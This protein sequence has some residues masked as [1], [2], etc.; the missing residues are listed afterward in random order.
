MAS[1]EE[2][3]DRQK[4][5]E[6]TK[7]QSNLIADNG[8]DGKV[9]DVYDILERS[10]NSVI[11]RLRKLREYGITDEMIAEL[12]SNTTSNVETRDSAIDTLAAVYKNLVR[13]INK[14]P[15]GIV[16]DPRTGEKNEAA[17]LRQA[18]RLGIDDNRSFGRL[19]KKGKEILQ[20]EL[21]KSIMKNGPKEN[22]KQN[23]RK[24]LKKFDFNEIL[25]DRSRQPNNE[26]KERRIENYMNEMILEDIKK[27][28]SL[29]DSSVDMKKIPLEERLKY[30]GT[31]IIG[32]MRAKLLPEQKAQAHSLIKQLYPELDGKEDNA[33]IANLLSE[34]LGEEI[35]HNDIDKIIEKV[36]VIKKEQIEKYRIRADDK[37][38]I[39]DKVLAMEARLQLLDKRSP[40]YGI[41]LKELGDFYVSHPEYR[42]FS[43]TL[44]YENGVIT[45]EA[46]AKISQYINDLR[47]DAIGS[48]I[49]KYDQAD[50]SKLTEE[51]KKS[52]ASFFLIAA[53]SESN[54]ELA[55]ESLGLLKEMYPKLRNKEE[56]EILKNVTN[57]VFTDEKVNEKNYTDKID[58]MRETLNTVLIEERCNM[59]AG[60]RVQDSKISDQEVNDIYDNHSVDLH[61]DVDLT[62]TA[63]QNKFNDSK[64]DFNREDEEF[65]NNLY[66]KS[67][68]DSWISSKDEA[69]FHKYMAAL[70]LDDKI[71]VD[72]PNLEAN[73]SKAVG[74]ILKNMRKR[75]PE[76]AKTI[77][78]YTPEELQQVKEK[79]KEFQKSKIN[80]KVIDFYQ[81]NLLSSKT[82]YNDLDDKEQYEFLK[83][84]LLSRGMAERADTPEQK[85]MFLKLS[86]RAFEL[87]NTKDKEFVSFDENGNAIINEEVL[88]DEY[89]EHTVT[90]Y[91]SSKSLAE[92]QKSVYDKYQRVYIFGKMTEYVKLKDSDFV[93]LEAESLD[94]KMDEINEIKYI[95]N[96]ERADEKINQQNSKD[97]VGSE[98]KDSTNWQ[99]KTE[100]ANSKQAESVV[101][102]Q[103]LVVQN[104]SIID[105]I[106][107]GFNDLKG[108]VTSYLNKDN[109]IFSKIKK[110]F[111][112]DGNQNSKINTQRD[113]LEGKTDTVQQNNSQENSWRVEGVTGKIDE[114]KI[115]KSQENGRKVESGERDEIRG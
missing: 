1:K 21:I 26:V 17:S 65:F 109:N 113:R 43:N 82:N 80:A 67:S 97:I 12:Y 74:N 11:T 40:E 28:Q 95:K 100:E 86:N 8:L 83:M 39:S 35:K 46:Q 48:I 7:D 110:T 19:Q 111:T 90:K 30:A 107:R 59:I 41:L 73:K 69:I 115:E 16:I 55:E 62:K 9:I 91:I 2:R 58:S 81:K 32:T 72:K 76:L 101:G 104:N 77:S 51:E 84:V 13:Y 96:K 105:K 36:D 29:V 99:L 33:L 87:M 94:G 112:K 52:Y 68:I 44:R 34:M 47:E 93:K 25:N 10:N 70:I 37:V 27:V 23:M 92:L 50:K 6:K 79:E 54:K 114:S 88:L 63:L 78:E 3:A 18:A 108:R 20:E 98:I 53:T 15:N 14:L 4:R 60:E 85:Q 38:K 57:I 71:V 89:R 61:L 56:K 75:Y 103:S 22:L 45:L 31:L 42:E 64:I 5:I 24:N 66:K 106:R 102:E 49:N